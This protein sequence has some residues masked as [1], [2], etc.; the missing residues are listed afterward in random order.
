MMRPDENE[1][2]IPS[3]LFDLGR[4][5]RHLPPDLPSSLHYETDGFG[6]EV[7]LRE[8]VAALLGSVRTISASR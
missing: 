7:Q 2:D 5:R 8:R 4:L 6:E 1:K 3:P